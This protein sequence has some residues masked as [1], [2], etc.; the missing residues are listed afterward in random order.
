MIG[1][2]KTG[3]Y[4]GVRYRETKFEGMSIIEGYDRGV[5]V[6]YACSKK[7]FQKKV[8]AYVATGETNQATPWNRRC[9]NCGSRRHAICD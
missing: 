1:R 6:I 4:L 5:R 7:E 9:S 2:M 8:K 3:S